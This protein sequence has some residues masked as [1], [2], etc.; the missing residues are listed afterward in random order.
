M[1]RRA[2]HCVR[3]LFGRPRV[4][5][6]AQHLAEPLASEVPEQTPEDLESLKTAAAAEAQAVE[7][8][9]GAAPQPCDE[10]PPPAAEA[11]CR[12]EQAPTEAGSQVPA[13]EQAAAAAETAAAAAAPVEPQRQQEKLWRRPARWRQLP[14]PPRSC[15]GRIGLQSRD[16]WRRSA[17]TQRRA[18]L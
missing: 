5:G 12:P 4:R 9:V 6:P 1:P 14:P 8:T 3:A 2:M 13:P 17:G 18:R 10:Q 7:A 11:A 15:S 16:L